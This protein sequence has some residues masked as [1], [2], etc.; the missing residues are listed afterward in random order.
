MRSMKGGVL[1]HPSSAPVCDRSETGCEIQLI[2]IMDPGACTSLQYLLAKADPYCFIFALCHLISIQRQ[3]TPQ[4]DSH[5]ANV[6]K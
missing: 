6:G 2:V 3:I 5:A 4:T 1:A